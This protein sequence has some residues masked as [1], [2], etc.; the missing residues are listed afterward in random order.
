VD[1]ETLHRL[2]P[3]PV[4]DSSVNGTRRGSRSRS[5]GV[6]GVESVT[7]L[8]REDILRT[9]REGLEAGG[10]TASERGQCAADRPSQCLREW[11]GSQCAVA[12]AAVDFIL[13]AGGRIGDRDSSVPLP[14][15]C[16]RRSP[17]RRQEQSRPRGGWAQRL[18]T[19]KACLRGA[20]SFH[21]ACLFPLSPKHARTAQFPFCSF[22]RPL[23]CAV[24]GPRLPQRAAATGTPHQPAPPC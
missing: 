15:V 22:H 8:L 21:S 24:P 13:W 14:V 11:K 5:S 18:D 9:I 16:P 4:A 7:T 3:L 12:V 10:W 23:L 2:V 19:T 6:V 1:V 17:H 20:W